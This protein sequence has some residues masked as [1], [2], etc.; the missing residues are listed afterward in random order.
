MNAIAASAIG[1]LLSNWWRNAWGFDWLYDWV[2]TKPYVAI[3]QLNRRDIC[4]QA[5][6]L[7]PRMTRGGHDAMAVTENGSVRWYVASM[8]IGAVLVLA[9][10]FIV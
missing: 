6:A 3:S 7:V 1:K 4:D 9:A 8:A 5:I 10:A 2:F